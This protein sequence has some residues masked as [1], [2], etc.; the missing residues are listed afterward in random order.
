MATMQDVARAAGVSLKTVSR[1]VNGESGVRPETATRVLASIASLEFRP[2]VAARSLR[3]GRS[4]PLLGLVI[5]DLANPF[6][7]AIARGVEE[8][9]ADQ[10][11]LVITGSSE[12]HA[13]REQDLL[14]TLYRQHIA[15]LLVVP[16]ADQPELNAAIR[17][18]KVCLDRPSPSGDADAVLLDNRGGAEQGVANLIALG[19][20]RIGVVG[21]EQS[22]FT[23]AERLAGY[24]AA[25]AVAG[26]EY[27]A[28]LVLL[29]AS[30]AERAETC[31]YR[32]LNREDFPS[33]IFAMNNRACIG[34][35][36]AVAARHSP[37]AVLGFDDL[38]L[39][40]LLP[41][42]H[43]LVVNDPMELG[44]A[45]TRLLLARMGGD[46]SP[47]RTIVLPTTLVVFGHGSLPGSQT[48][49]LSTSGSQ[50]G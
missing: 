35:L 21:D 9:A 11:Y 32:L 33:A 23:A 19:H 37:I 18:P 30:T 3:V 47:W 1:V 7:S 24:R 20:R 50:V 42:L 44:R 13:N 39:A 14:S 16:A 38:E 2:N 34:V 17:V 41:S 10:G 27:D 40:G 48:A 36:R 12:E 31:A 29:G 22:L 15:G 8:V 4:L 43:A 26:I 25:L 6:Y 46:D 28:S 5:G 49:A 45:G